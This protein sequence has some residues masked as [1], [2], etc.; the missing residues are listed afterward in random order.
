MPK[1]QA[2]DANLI[3]HLGEL[4]RIRVP[5]DRQEEL[6]AKLQQLVVAFSTLAETDFEAA[7]DD[8]NAATNMRTMTADELRKDTAETP[9][10]VDQVLANAPQTAAH[11]FV[12]ARV[13]EP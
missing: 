12:V 5:E 9:P 7:G 6:R 11:C 3:A 10:S 4:A 8:A 1:P 2:I 13:V